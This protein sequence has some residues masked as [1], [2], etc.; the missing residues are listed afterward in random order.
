MDSKEE[1]A[2]AS[3]VKE[4]FQCAFDRKGSEEK[5]NKQQPQL[6]RNQNEV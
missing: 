5:E 3:S 2:L 1:C 6:H 4:L